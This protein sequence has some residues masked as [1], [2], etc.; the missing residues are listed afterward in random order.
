MPLSSKKIQLLPEHL[1][2]QIKAGEV[3]ERPGSLIKETLENSLDAGSTKIEIKILNNGLDLISIKDNGSGIEYED[4][5]LAFS[6][7]AT[8]KI[9]QFEDLYTL[10]TYGFRGEALASIASISKVQCL[11]SSENSTYGGEIHIEGGLQTYHGKTQTR[12]HGTEIIIQNLFYNTPARMKFIQSQ[13][14]EKRFLK[15]VIYSFI[16]SNPNTEFHIQFDNDDKDIFSSQNSILERIASIFPKTKNLIQ[17]THKEYDGYQ[18]NLYLLPSK[19]KYPI[20]LDYFFINKR[21]IF[22]KQFHRVIEQS[23]INAFGENHFHYI[24]LLESPKDGIDVNVHPHKTSVKCFESS[25]ILSLISSSIKGMSSQGPSHSPQMTRGSFIQQN[26]LNLNQNFLDLK[27]KATEIHQN[28]NM[29]GIFSPHQSSLEV[30]QNLFWIDSQFFLNNQLFGDYVFNAKTLLYEYIFN[31]CQSP[32][33]SYPLLV[34]IPFKKNQIKQQALDI[35]KNAGSEIDNLDEETIVIRAIPEWM[36]TMPIKDIFDSLLKF[37]NLKNFEITISD[38]PSRTWETM[39]QHFGISEI[40][41]KG[42]AI[43]LSELLKEKLK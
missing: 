27:N 40:V 15:K 38:W 39:I 22:D 4:L 42:I 1:I 29:E 8:S 24:A 17:E 37:N 12:P 16:F 30:K 5:P 6:R 26:E 32:S 19:I 31:K 18:F 35:I 36:S 28:Y 7:H 33:I 3:V 43:N 34:S 41:K 25:K 13:V 11:S 20:P 2:D 23:L 21:M 10:Y 9:N 14:S